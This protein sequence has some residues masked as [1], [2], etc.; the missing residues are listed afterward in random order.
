MNKLLIIAH[1]PLAGALR[2]CAL[3]VFPDICHDLIAIDIL[4][5]DSA[6]KS[7]DKV[8]QALAGTEQDSLLIMTDI[9][10]A[11]PCNVAMQIVRSPNRRLVAGVNLPML[12]RAIT[13]RH[14]NLDNWVQ[15]ATAGGMQ[16]VMPV[17]V[18][19]PQ[20]QPKKP[21]NDQQQHYD[22]Q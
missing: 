18:S 4:A 8:E 16:G 15:K 11:T 9:F 6:E 1:E 19:A 12:L 7:V 14:E 21:Q 17:A 13:Y 5:H 22:Q 2:Q 3:H 20:N 10:G